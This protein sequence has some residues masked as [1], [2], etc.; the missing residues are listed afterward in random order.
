L[1]WSGTEYGAVWSQGG[2]IIFRRL[3]RAG[4]TIGTA[5]PLTD[6][7][8]S[9]ADE[10]DIVWTGSEYGVVWDQFVG[11]QQIRFAHVSRQG[12]LMSQILHIT[13]DASF[14]GNSRPRV[15]WGGG[16]YGITWLGNN[17]FQ[18]EIFFAR[19]DPRQGPVL[20]SL[21][22]TTHNSG[23]RHP[24]LAW[25]GSEW[26][27]VWQDHQTFT[28]VYFQRVSALGAL[29]GGNVRITNA[30]G[31]SNEPTLVW[32][33]SEYGVV[34]DDFRSGELELWFARISSTG[35][36][37]GS[38]LQLTTAAGQSDSPS[39]AWGGGKFAVAWHDDLN[40]G[41]SE[42]LFLRLGCNCVD[43][44]GDTVSSCVDCDD[45]RAA[46]YGGAPQICDGFNNDCN[47][48]SWPLLTGTNEADVDGDSF[49]ACTDCND[50]NG[51]IW[52]TPGEVRSLV[53]THNQL[54][55][56]STISW[57]A[58]ALPGA[59]TD[60]YDTVRATT[61]ANFISATCVETNDGPNTSST[62]ATALAPGGAFFYL[63]RAENG[64]PSG[65]GILGRNG[66]GTP[67]PGRTCP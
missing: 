32:T 59:T 27:I 29:V 45:T 36:K 24:Q 54:S 31:V 15:A 67:T 20:P 51:A 12:N 21:Q 46:V 43:T 14:F 61:P 5:T 41:E 16:K 25:N 48:T 17:G 40:A 10:P 2:E 60:L 47:N 18:S 63:V 11:P 56:V 53:M 23:V 13:D 58:P 9:S 4:A 50:A 52:A 28:E 22:V 66:A 37:I 19:V 65:Q 30:S 35:A 55:S 1:V 7:A 3:D 26:G 6:A 8:G 33:G 38:D 44:D 39:L 42:I 62:D 64:C 49:S 57:T 34:W